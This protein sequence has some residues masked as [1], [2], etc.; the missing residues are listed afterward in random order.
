MCHT[1]NIGMRVWA[2]GEL[3]KNEEKDGEHDADRYRD[4]EPGH[5]AGFEPL[6]ARD[7]EVT[8]IKRWRA[9][10]RGVVHDQ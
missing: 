1:W 8:F 3:R 9:P 2:V 5:E 4:A 6:L 7:P 10:R